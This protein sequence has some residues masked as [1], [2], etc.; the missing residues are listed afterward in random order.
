[1]TK[2]E[3]YLKSIIAMAGNPN[4][5]E[6]KPF[7]DDKNVIT[8]T[9]LTEEIMMDAER[10]LNETEKEWPEAF[11]SDDLEERESLKTS[12]QEIAKAISGQLNVMVE[13]P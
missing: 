1:M 7:E 2:K 10:L 5:V 13:E 11:E 12:L 9:L 8:H 6:V 3:F 4:Y